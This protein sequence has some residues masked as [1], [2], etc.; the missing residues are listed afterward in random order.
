MQHDMTRN[1]GEGGRQKVL[2]NITHVY[3]FIMHVHK[4]KTNAVRRLKRLQMTTTTSTTADIA[5]S[6]V[7]DIMYIIITHN[8]IGTYY[9]NHN[10]PT[11]SGRRSSER[12]R[13]G[14]RQ[15]ERQSEREGERK[16]RGSQRL[17]VINSSRCI[18]ICIIFYYTIHIQYTYIYMLYIYIYIQHT[19]Y[20]NIIYIIYCRAINHDRV[21]AM[22]VWSVGGWV[23]WSTAPRSVRGGVTEK[24]VERGPRCVW[25]LRVGARASVLLFFFVIIFFS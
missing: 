7:I 25:E 11:C 19:Q 20:H 17:V 15:M 13:Q 24:R 16:S 2:Y 9:N 3:K 14:E 22:C 5:K 8:R 18:P 4:K 10:S 21:N 6:V 1:G 12:E 23:E